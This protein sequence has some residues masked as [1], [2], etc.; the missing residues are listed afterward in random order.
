MD[1][2]ISRWAQALLQFD[3]IRFV[4]ID[5]TSIKKDADIIR[6]FTLNKHGFIEEAVTIFSVRHPTSPNTE[7][8]GITQEEMSRGLE[9]DVVWDGIVVP[10]LTGKFVLAYGFDF[11]QERLDENAAT[12]RL[13]PVHLIGDC[14]MQ[15]AVKYFRSTNYGMKLIDAC[16]RIGHT[17]PARPNAE[18][19]AQGQLALL[20]AMAEGITSAPTQSSDEGLGDLESHPF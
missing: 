5:T 19:R 4:V 2:D 14:L 15:T 1:N 18:Q 9:L 20:K 10:A 3:N 8:T 7:W 16:T 6:F 17:L 13:K 12:Y 11:L